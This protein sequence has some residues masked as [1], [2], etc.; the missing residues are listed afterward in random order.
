[1]KSGFIK[2]SLPLIT[3][4]LLVLFAFLNFNGGVFATSSSNSD[5]KECHEDSCV[6]HTQSPS[7]TPHNDDCDESHDHDGEDCDHH[8]SPSPSL[9]P[10]PSPTPNSCDRENEDDNHVSFWSLFNINAEAHYL[11]SPTPCP[12]ATPKPSPSPSPSPSVSPSPTPPN[13][14]NCEGQTSIGD[15][16]HYDNGTHW[17]VGDGLLVG[18]DDV[19]SIGNQNYMQCYCPLSSEYIAG[20]EGIQTN[21]ESAHTV[22]KPADRSGYFLVWGPDFGLDQSWFYATGANKPSPTTPNFNCGEPHPSPSP[23]PSYSPSPSVSPSPSPIDECNQDGANCNTGGT[24]PTPSPSPSVSPSPES[25]ASASPSTDNGSNNNNNNN[26]NSNNNSVGGTVLVASTGP[27]VLA[28]TGSANLYAIGV[29]G[30]GMIA[31]GLWQLKRSRR[32]FLLQN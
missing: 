21:W 19:Y 20:D 14:P 29:A 32:A 22:N 5:S 10:K 12:T 23:S 6:S 11:P 28:D 27:Q 4:V 8:A 1:M 15:K 26:N 31:A 30:F 24:E 18:R 2:I 7:P 17:V 25:T 9:S 16:A 13:F 3:S